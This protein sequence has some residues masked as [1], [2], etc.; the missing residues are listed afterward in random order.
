MPIQAVLFDLGGVILRTEYQAPREHLAERLNSSYE[1]LV[2]IV[3]ESESARRASLGEISTQQHWEAVVGR[4]RRPST[5]IPELRDE[6]FAGDVLDRSL[7]DYIRALRKRRRSGLISNAWPDMREYIVSNK[8]ED[9]FDSIIISSEVGI[10]KPDP[11][12]FEL[13][14]GGLEVQPSQAVLVDDTPANIDGARA[15]G[16]AGVI[17]RDPDQMKRDLEALLD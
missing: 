10:L 13:A 2:R 11:G 6:F 5:E 17:F 16:M 8:I 7:V 14:L 12:I 9:A 4:L 1:D 15:L 3:F